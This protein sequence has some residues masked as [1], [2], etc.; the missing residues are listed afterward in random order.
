MALARGEAQGAVK[1]GPSQGRG[2][3]C[4]EIQGHSPNWGEAQGAVK[5]RDIALARTLNIRLVP[6]INPS[7]NSHGGRLCPDT[8]HGT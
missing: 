2:T 4:C 6:L 1:H 8:C 3:G 5:Y 7:H